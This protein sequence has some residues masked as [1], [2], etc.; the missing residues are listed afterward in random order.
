VSNGSWDGWVF[1]RNDEPVMVKVIPAPPATLVLAG[2]LIVGCR[3]RRA[4]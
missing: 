3:R 4:A 2:L 1:G